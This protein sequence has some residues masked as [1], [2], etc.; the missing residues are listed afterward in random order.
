MAD[1]SEQELN[2]LVALSARYVTAL[3]AQMKE[4]IL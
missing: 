2:Q 4:M 1:F 3:E